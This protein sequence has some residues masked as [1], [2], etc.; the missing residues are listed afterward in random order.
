MPLMAFSSDSVKNFQTVHVEDHVAVVGHHAL[1][2]FGRPPSFT[3]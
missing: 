2:I 3:S 1:T